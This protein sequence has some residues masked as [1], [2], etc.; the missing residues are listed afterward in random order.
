MPIIQ[1]AKK[2]AR[3]TIKRTEHNKQIKKDIKTAIKAFRDTPTGEN[4]AVAQSELD[5][6]VKKGLLKLNTA[7]RRKAALYQVAKAAG[8]VAKEAKKVEKSAKTAAAKPATAKKT[9]AKKAPAAK[10]TTTTKKTTTSKTAKPAAK[11]PAPK[12]KAESK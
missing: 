10:K 2:A 1:S 4:L 7:S 8:V 11:K 5:K 3:Q 9:P 12:P 6:A